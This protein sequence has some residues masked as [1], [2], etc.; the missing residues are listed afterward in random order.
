M[1]WRVGNDTM[2]NWLFCPKCGYNLSGQWG[3]VRASVPGAAAGAAPVGE[4]P[5]TDVPNVVGQCPECGREYQSTLLAQDQAQ[6][7]ITT[8]RMV[9]LLM[10][11]PAVCFAASAIPVIGMLGAP[12]GLLVTASVGMVLA[13]KTAGRLA[14]TR[15]VNDPTGTTNPLDPDFLRRATWGLCLAELGLAFL[16]TFGGCAIAIA[17]IQLH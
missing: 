5:T 8:K 16:A 9:G 3:A 2:A 11:C 1:A 10:I 12:I 17:T 6:K 13:R 14:F 15:A 7:T 4:V